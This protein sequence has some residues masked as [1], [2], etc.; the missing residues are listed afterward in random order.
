MKLTENKEFLAELEAL[1]EKYTNKTETQE[2]KRWRDNEDANIEG[3]FID[4]EISKVFHTEE[5]VPSDCFSV[6]AT[7]VQ[8]KSA[9][10]M[11]RISQI[12]ANDERFGGVVTDEE[13][14]DD[15]TWKYFIY[16][17]DD[18]ITTNET[19]MEWH[20]LAFHEPEQRNLF[21]Q[22]NEDLIRNYF[23]LPKKG[24]EK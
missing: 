15:S 20:F 8:A 18:A 1:V 21:L 6:F 5:P 10:A 14:H 11:A 23:M 2:A 22:E 7:E 24:G 4:S 9:L 17:K 13:W 3:Y 19:G 12:M 16:R